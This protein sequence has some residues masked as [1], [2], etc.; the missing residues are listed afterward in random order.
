MAEGSKGLKDPRL[1]SA[2]AAVG[3]IV[4]SLVLTQFLLPDGTPGA[5]LFQGLVFGML[6]GLIAVG[7][8]LIYRSS[9]VINFAQAAIGAAGAVFTYNFA[10]LEN[11][12]FPIALFAGLFVAAAMGALIE[13]GIV[14]R[15]FRA[16]RLVLTVLTIALIGVLSGLAAQFDGLPIFKPLAD[17]STEEA[18][19]TLPLPIPF[20][21]FSFQVGSFPLDFGSA[22][23][24]A[25]GLALLAIVGLAA[26]LRFT[27]FGI[28]IR[29]AADNVDRAPMLGINVGTLST[30]VWTIAGL[31]SGIGFIVAGAASNTF[32]IGGAGVEQLLI[33]LSAAVIARMYSIPGAL[34]AAVLITM[35]KQAVGFSFE[36][37]APLVDAGLLAILL[38][39]LLIGQVR[40]ARSDS[41][42]KSWE[43]T[44]EYRPIPRE[45]LGV[46]GLK[47]WRW[48][49]IAVGVLAVIIFPFA[50]PTR[51]ISTAGFVA[52]Q[53][54]AMLSLVVVTGWSGQVSLGQWGLVGIGALLGGY[55]TATLGLN[56]WLALIIL[57]LVVGAFALLI[58]LPALRIQGLFL[59]IVTLAFAFVVR[60]V[61]F[62][63]NFFGW[64][65]TNDVTRPTLLILDFDDERSM[66]FLT[67]VV[68]VL[69]VLLVTGLR[70]S[71]VGRVLIGVRE[72][73]SNALSFGVSTVKAR[74]AAFAISGYICGVSGVM[75]AHH[76]RAVQAVD[77]GAITSLNIFLFAVVGG[78]GSITGVI[79]GAT[80][81]AIRG[82]FAANEFLAFI[83]Q[84]VAIL[85]FLYVAPG[86]LA[87][88]FYGVRDATL[89]IVAQRRQMVVPSLFADMDPETLAGQRIP[90][91]DPIPNSGLQGLPFDQ[92]YRTPSELYSADSWLKSRKPKKK[93][94]D[95]DK[96]ALGAAVETFGET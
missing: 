75:W 74:L 83:F 4:G 79:L 55:A 27:R 39:A 90:L 2:L 17:R 51:L 77:F 5:V 26:Y 91:S 52:L 86:G 53:G 11:W 60:S 1:L 66:Y 57:P 72:N 71:R 6:N 9:Q 28:A 61:L 69:M 8:V 82:L 95:E 33:A 43:A 56:F 23:I 41:A 3:G 35:V 68:V 67:V 30:V 18:A 16:P 49:A 50:A 47:I 76:Q 63:D 24:F 29:A 59:A 7:I 65:I 45:M 10:V 21:D 13:L 78:V 93:P 92:R 22:D 36:A 87:S 37:Q 12:P 88:I 62:N 94:T 54:L 46:G 44:E 73:Q 48:V 19:K 32:S 89:R 42:E 84:D 70:R 31:L 14:R 85:A 96:G 34:L 81:F 80:Y 64:L 25:I 38:G 58:G 15:F 40:A 20:E